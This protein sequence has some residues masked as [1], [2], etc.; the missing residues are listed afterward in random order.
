MGRKVSDEDLEFIKENWLTM[1]NIDMAYLIGVDPV[2]VSQ[3]GKQLGLPKK[4]KTQV[5]QYNYKRTSISPCIENY[6]PGPDTMF[7]E[8]GRQ[9]TLEL[10]RIA[11]EIKS[12]EK[13][14]IKFKPGEANSKPRILDGVVIQHNDFLVALKVKNYVETFKY[15]EFYTGRAVII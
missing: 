9:K 5:N 1:S 15:I 2:A 3:K 4:T 7:E 14:R 12:K 10:K 11:E 8:A 6:G 13:L